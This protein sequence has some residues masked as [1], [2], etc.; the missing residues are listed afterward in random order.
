MWQARR[1]LYAWIKDGAAIYVCGDAKAMAKD[2]HN[3]LLAVIADQSGA[4]PEAA[5]QELRALQ[6][7]GRYKRDVY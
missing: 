2:V 1:D 5:A 6:R 7:D 4:G 3:A